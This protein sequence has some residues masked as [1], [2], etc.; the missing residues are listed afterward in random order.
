M[1]ATPARAWLLILVAVLCA[2]GIALYRKSTVGAFV[3]LL[4]AFCLLVVGVAHL[5]EALD[6]FP[7]M[8]WGLDGSAGHYTDL[9]C[10]ILA[11]PLLVLGRFIRR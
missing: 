9:V 5:F 2:L 4:G 6:W 3:Q 8:G 7:A 1:S 11:L 10:A